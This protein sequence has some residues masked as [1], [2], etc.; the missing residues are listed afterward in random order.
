[1]LTAHLVQHYAEDIRTSVNELILHIS[2]HHHLYLAAGNRKYHTVYKAAN[3]QGV[4]NRQHRRR[5]DEYV[6]CLL[7]TSDAADD[8]YSV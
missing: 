2:R 7:Y 6:I 3:Y 8:D 1:M 5:V 4:R